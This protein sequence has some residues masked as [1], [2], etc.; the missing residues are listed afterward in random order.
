M[1]RNGKIA[2]LPR[3][4]RDVICQMMIDGRTVNDIRA[5]VPECAEFNDRSFSA[6]RGTPG[7]PSGFNDWQKEQERL[8]D[9]KAKREFALEIVKENEGSQIHEAAT[10]IAASQIYELLNDF[11]VASLKEKLEG[12]PKGFA[13]LVQALS[14]LADSG[15]KYQRYHAEV[16]AAKERMQNEL[17]AS[18]GTGGLKPETI[19]RIEREL[20]LL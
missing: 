12:N 2:R 6:W 10:Q 18:K 8:S 4:I 7:Q 16:Q 3:A 5:E 14:K 13:S 19:E 9:M 17:E 1:T 20:K 15:L 11:D